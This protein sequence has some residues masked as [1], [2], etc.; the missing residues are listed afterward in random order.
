MLYKFKDKHKTTIKELQELCGYLNFIC[1]AIFP[2]RPF[3]RRMYAKYSKYVK[4][5]SHRREVKHNHMYTSQLKAHHHVGLDKEFR[6]DCN[7]WIQFL[8][9]SSNL[10][11]IVNH[12]MIDVLEPAL[13]SVEICFYSDVSAAVNLGFGCIFNTQWIQGFWGDHGDFIQ[14]C[15]PSIE[16]LELFALVAGILT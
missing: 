11:K 13:T 2:G 15:E 10:N 12:P 9:Q 1:K 16:Y 6:E 7:I 8:D 14:T 3:L 5:P 4:I